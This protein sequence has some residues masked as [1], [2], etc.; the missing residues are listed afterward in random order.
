ME[1]N[2]AKSISLIITTYNRVDLLQKALTS[3]AACKLPEST[4]VEV[5]IV[6]NNSTDNT[7]EV[8]KN[9][10]QD[11]P[12]RLRYVKELNQ[13]LSYARNRGLREAQGHY[14]VFMDDDEMME[15]HYLSRLPGVFAETDAVCVGGPVSYYNVK[16]MPRWL[17]ALSETTGQITYGDKV[18]ELGRGTHKGLN[19][20]NMAFIRTELVEAGGY[21][22]RLGRRGNELLTGED[23][24]LQDRL[25]D[26]GKR[27]VYHP[28]LI[29]HHYMR[30][31]RNNKRYWRDLY[32][33]YGRTLHLRRCAA[34]NAA[35]D[36][37]F[38]GAPL[39][40]WRQLIAGDIP[41]YTRALF[42][43]D[44]VRLFRRELDIWTRLGQ[45]SEARRPVAASEQP[46]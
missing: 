32:F 13:G 29:Q 23:Y 30:P 37:H 33:A 26:R 27:I 12:M 4:D 17:E 19:G 15:E 22:V 42:Q 31:E 28:K 9:A 34:N 38:L 21:D 8:V 24:E 39:W 25:R 16:K 2:P 3:V 36:R 6:D 11:F 7:A 43:F 1:G 35:P 20:G 44:S 46:A 45:I 5:V 40:L 14:I 41:A 10:A 18:K